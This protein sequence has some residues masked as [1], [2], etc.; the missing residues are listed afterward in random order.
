MKK[1]QPDFTLADVIAAL[2]ERCAEAGSQ[3]AFAENNRISAQHVSDVL[4]RKSKPGP[5][6]L[7]ALG[8][9]KVTQ[10]QVI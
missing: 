8:F 10:Y 5:A 2:S 1:A 9:Y 4:N 6:I 7:R 3:R